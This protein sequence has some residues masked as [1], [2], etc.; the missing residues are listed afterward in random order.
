LRAWGAKR[1]KYPSVGH[2]AT[3]SLV[4]ETNQIMCHTFR[5]PHKIIAEHYKIIAEHFRERDLRRLPRLSRRFLKD[6][7]NEEGL[8]VWGSDSSPPQEQMTRLAS[9]LR[10]YGPNKLLWVSEAGPS[11]PPATAETVEGWLLHGFTDR[12]AP[13]SHAADTGP[14]GCCFQT[15]SDSQLD[16]Y[17]PRTDPSPIMSQQIWRVW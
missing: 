16:P 1:S 6:P 17:P 9:A 10:W 7:K 8:L 11:H 12:L 13:S 4:Q 14:T 2:L 3:W 15:E 5:N